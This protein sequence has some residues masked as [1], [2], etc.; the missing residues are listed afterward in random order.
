MIYKRKELLKKNISKYSDKQANSKMIK[1]RNT[2]NLAIQNNFKLNLKRIFKYK[3]SIKNNFYFNNLVIIMIIIFYSFYKNI[4]IIQSRMLGSLS[5]YISIKIDGTG[6]QEIINS[7]FYQMPDIIYCNGLKVDIINKNKIIIN[8]SKSIVLLEWNNILKNLSQIF[9]NLTNISEIDLSNFDPSNVISMRNMFYGCINVEKINFGNNFNSLIVNNLYRMFYNCILLTSLN[10]SNFDTS[11]VSVMSDMFYRC[12]SLKILDI[13]NF[14]TSIVTRMEKMFN[15]CSSILTLNLSHFKTNLIKNFDY[16]FNECQSLIS[17]DITNFNTSLVTNMS[18]MFAGCKNLT[19]LDLSNFNTES[20]KYMRH[21]FDKCEKLLSLDLSNFKILNLVNLEKIFANCISLTSVDL[22]SF[23]TS[24]IENFE[25]MFYNC[26]SLT[27]LNLSFFDTSLAIDMTYMFAGC[28]NLKYINLNSFKEKE[29]VDTTNM[30]LD[31]PDN[32]IYCINNDSYISNISSLLISKICSV[33]DCEEN[34]EY[35]KDMKFE[36]KKKS[37]KIFDDK[38][39]YKSIEEVS[40]DFILTDKIPDT[41]IYSYDINSNI[42]ELKN[43]YTNLTFVELSQDQINY[44]REIF[45]IDDNE[46]IYFLVIDSKSEDPMT[47]TSW[48]DYKIIL[49]NGTELNMSNIEIDMKVNMTVPIRN[50]DLANFEIAEKL[51]NQGYDIY[52]KENDFYTDVCIS[53]A[54]DDNDITIEDRKKDVFPNNVTLCKNDCKY[55]GVN[56]EDK[57]VICECSLVS[58]NNSSSSF[59]NFL[60]YF[61]ADDGN[62][63]TY[64]LDNIN[65][66]P[67]QC[68]KLLAFASNLK[69]NYPFYIISF[70]LI[71]IIAITIKFFIYKLSILR[72]YLFKESP[73]EQKLRKSI[74]KD[75]KK[76]NR[77][78]PENQRKI[79]FMN[80]CNSKEINIKRNTKITINEIKAKKNT[81]I[82]IKKNSNLLKRNTHKSL[83]SSRRKISTQNFKNSTNLKILSCEH[84]IMRE[85][86]PIP[87]ENNVEK[88]NKSHQKKS[89]PDEKNNKDDPNE[90]PY[91]QAI[92]EDKRNIFQVFKS[93]LFSK[94]LI[95]NLFIEEYKIKEIAVCEYILSLLIAFFFNALL[96]SDE[97]VS[98]KY[99]NN[100]NLDFIVTFALSILSNILT[101]II[102]YFL[103]YSPLIEERLE[104]IKEIK[105]E[106]EY[107][108]ILNK[109]FRILKIKIIIFLITEIFVIIICFYYIV[110]FCIIYKRSQMSLLINYLSSLAEEIIKALIIS[111]IVV[112]T[113]KIGI[114]CLNKYIYNTSKYINEK[115]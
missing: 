95:I 47:A 4:I 74:T 10:L 60:N 67:F 8:E 83:N 56:I 28:T 105:Y 41:T 72:V 9:T 81:K 61:L 78:S 94:I 58:N 112:L 43:Q 76:T 99:H 23:N 30:F 22:S 65:F 21:M 1:I 34:W 2:E 62:A 68:G 15:Y 110:I 26:T 107:M 115:F 19:S 45:N 51:S 77:K 48:Y 114:S 96:Y 50:L 31:T 54:I 46:K 63:W 111:S 66:K 87:L 11:H 39:V 33:N 71:V 73:L 70:I 91:T 52:D 89:D 17:L 27:S 37:I 18:Y 57:R 113:R 84:L 85:S 86:S 109:F 97:V 14:D 24:L 53:A 59:Q 75:K 35:N 12:S 64:L 38:C 100:G 13:S 32:L 88:N 82:I 36:E 101:S 16:M 6:E 40:Y 3:F 106:Y 80:N 103:E 98:H 44:L 55:K 25:K 108:K 49:G 69:Y 29:G 90:M 7:Y 92:R 42:D 20:V 104:Q 79:N 93:I 5:N 102:Q